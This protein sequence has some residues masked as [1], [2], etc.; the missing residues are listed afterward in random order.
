MNPVEQNIFKIAEESA[1]KNGF[2]LVDLIFRGN[3]RNKVIEVFVDGEGKVS[4]ENCAQI[5][6]DIVSE[7]KTLPE[8]SSNFRL[9]VSTPGVDRPLKYLK[10]FPKHIG[11][12]FDVS[13]RFNE[14]DRQLTGRLLNIIGDELLFLTD[15]KEEVLINFGSITKAKVLISFS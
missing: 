12:K 14:E 3:E 4:A 1:A 5:S 9:D 10:Q 8:L 11:R 6:R 13:F 7:L 15:K 2:F